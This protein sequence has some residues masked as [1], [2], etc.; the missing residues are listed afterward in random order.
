MNPRLLYIFNKIVVNQDAGA[1]QRR[2]SHDNQMGTNARSAVVNYG[3]RQQNPTSASR[4][5]RRGVSVPDLDSTSNIESRE[6]PIMVTV[7]TEEEMM[8]TTLSP[9]YSFKSLE[10]LSHD[11]LSRQSYAGP[12]SA[13]L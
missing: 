3:A 2:G 11:F 1:P 8:N 12:G 7:E 9:R 13:G 10:T 6:S 5:P 4:P